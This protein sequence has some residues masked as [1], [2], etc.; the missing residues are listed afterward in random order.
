MKTFCLY[1]YPHH[2]C[3]LHCMPSFEY[4]PSRIHCL[5]F[6][7]GRG[8]WGKLFLSS[9]GKNLF[10]LLISYLWLALLR[11]R[12]IKLFC[13]GNATPC[14]FHSMYPS[15]SGIGLD[16]RCEN[17]PGIMLHIWWDCSL[18]YP[19]WEKV[20]TLYNTLTGSDISIPPSPLSRNS[21]HDPRIHFISQ[22]W[23]PQTLPNGYQNCDTEPLEILPI[24][25]SW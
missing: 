9:N 17:A 15:V 21:F 11:R 8:N 14:F 12:I 22:M 4:P 13:D 19:L 23:P 18:I 7:L 16:W 5:T 10:Y 1:L 25:L 6:W 24:S 20:F 3:F 2:I